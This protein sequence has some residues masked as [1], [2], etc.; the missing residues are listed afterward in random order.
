MLINALMEKQIMLP[1]S[2]VSLCIKDI[3][4]LNGDGQHLISIENMQIENCL[5]LRLLPPKELL[6]LS[7]FVVSINE[8]PLFHF[9]YN[10]PITTE[11]I[12]GQ[13]HSF[14]MKEWNWPNIFACVK[15]NK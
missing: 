3:S 15:I 13:L 2:L 5:N 6:P 10:I 7:L 9:F 12:L 8:C 4:F 1:S 14:C 11:K